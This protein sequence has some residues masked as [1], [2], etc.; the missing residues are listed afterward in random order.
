MTIY[1]VGLI[2][3]DRD[4]LVGYFIT[5]KRAKMCCD[6]L[7]ITDPSDYEDHEWRIINFNLNETDYEH[8]LK[9][10]ES[11]EVFDFEQQME[12]IKHQ[13]LEELAR[14]KAKYESN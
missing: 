13:E 6:W 10:H 5:Y 12:K 2:D 4:E 3:Y 7:N 11:K 1:L 9:E 8:L 14:L